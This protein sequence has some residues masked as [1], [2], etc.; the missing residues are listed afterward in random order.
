MQYMQVPVFGKSHMLQPGEKNIND[1]KSVQIP[2][3]RF[4]SRLGAAA[5]AMPLYAR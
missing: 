1:F 2:V 4:R 3:I 5:A